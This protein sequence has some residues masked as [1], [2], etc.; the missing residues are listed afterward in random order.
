MDALEEQLQ[1]EFV[2]WVSQRLSRIERRP[3]SWCAKWWAHPEAVDRLYALHQ[4]W[5]KGQRNGTLVSWWTYDWAIQWPA[6]TQ[7]GGVLGGCTAF[8]HVDPM[9][10]QMR[11]EDLP[12]GTDLQLPF[13]PTGETLEDV[14]DDLEDEIERRLRAEQASAEE[15]LL[16]STSEDDP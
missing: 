12:R 11:F 10:P 13:P 3:N 16:A 5:E 7:P 1:D 9:L 15:A 8:E 14:D 4:A 6:L 2:R